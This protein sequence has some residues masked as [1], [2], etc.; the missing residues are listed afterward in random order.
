MSAGAVIGTIIATT[1]NPPRHRRYTEVIALK[2]SAALARG[3]LVH[4]RH[5]RAAHFSRGARIVETR[6]AVSI[7]PVERL[8]GIE[9]QK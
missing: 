1:A 5:A 4:D 9:R 3:R 8:P 6:T 2:M 7:A